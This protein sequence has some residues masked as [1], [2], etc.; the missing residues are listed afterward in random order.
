MVGAERPTG[1]SQRHAC[2]PTVAAA[3][4]QA[5]RFQSAERFAKLHGALAA[6]MLETGLITNRPALVVFTALQMLFL[7]SAK[8]GRPNWIIACPT[9]M[10]KRAGIKARK[11]KAILAELVEM[12]FLT[13]H[14]SH[15]SHFAIPTGLI[16]IGPGPGREVGSSVFTHGVLAFEDMDES[17]RPPGHALARAQA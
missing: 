4:A 3:S 6:L 16:S 2:A 13:E 1:C 12:N 5:P 15:R 14:G 17:V 7:R 10:S 11:I 8:L 9:A